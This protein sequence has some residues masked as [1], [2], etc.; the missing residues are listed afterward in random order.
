[1]AAM[2][3]AVAHPPRYGST[4]AE[5]CGPRARNPLGKK[6]ALVNIAA[7]PP[8]TAPGTR[9][10]EKRKKKKKSRDRRHAASASEN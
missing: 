2:A 4:G 9:R 6:S 8:M 5:V 7:G 10:N 1:M 3:A